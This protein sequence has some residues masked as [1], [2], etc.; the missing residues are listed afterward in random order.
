MNLER[1]YG[2]SSHAAPKHG[3]LGLG[4]TD[5]SIDVDHQGGELL[6]LIV[7]VL[8]EALDPAD[9]LL[10]D[11]PHLL[12]NPSH[13]VLRV[14]QSEVIRGHQIGNQRSASGTERQPE[15]FRGHQRP[16]EA[17]GRARRG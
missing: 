11:E 13:E 8:F 9:G 10:R 3:D 6:E 14:R 12:G 1:T 4:S 15:A 16:S 5:V 2:N 17:P 7:A